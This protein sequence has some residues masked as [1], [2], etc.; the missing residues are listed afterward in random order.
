MEDFENYNKYSKHIYYTENLCLEV[1]I[2]K[3]RSED[4]LNQKVSELISSDNRWGVAGPLRTTEL[5]YSNKFIYS[6]KL[7]KMEAMKHDY[8][9]EFDKMM[10]EFV[11]DF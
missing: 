10:D 8:N 5:G 2:V 4:E 1:R 9:A 6:I 11:S 7:K 3:A